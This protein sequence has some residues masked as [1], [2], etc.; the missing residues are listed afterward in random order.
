MLYAIHVIVLTGKDGF[1]HIVDSDVALEFVAGQG[2][3]E[4]SQCWPL[5]E[6]T[7]TVNYRETRHI[8]VHVL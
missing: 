1:P 6:V 8:H 2:G 3:H 7:I 5:S 4:K